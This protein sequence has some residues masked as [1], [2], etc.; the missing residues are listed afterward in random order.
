[1]PTTL[2]LWA[3]EENHPKPVKPEKLDLESRL[4]DWVAEDIS[5]IS[6]DLLIIGRQVP[7][8]YGGI[9]DILALNHEGDLVVVELKRDKTPRDI[10]AQVLDYASC[11]DGWGGSK[12]E[13]VASDYLGDAPLTEA[14]RTKFKVEYPDVL[15]T[16][17]RL[18]IVATHLDAASERIVEFLSEKYGVVY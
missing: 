12:I 18:Y 11:L 16:R 15:N 13:E 1:M 5:L 14:F 6:E 3:I 2:K 8:E 9:I 10:V 17:C 4:E 7:T